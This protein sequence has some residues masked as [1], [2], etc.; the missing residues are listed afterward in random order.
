MLLLSEEGKTERVLEKDVEVGKRY[1]YRME[2]KTDEEGNLLISDYISAYG[3]SM[4]ICTDT[5]E[6]PVQTPF[7]SSLDWLHGSMGDILHTRYAIKEGYHIIQIRTK[8]GFEF[9]L[10]DSATDNPTIIV[11]RVEHI[12]L[13][14]TLNTNHLCVEVV[15]KSIASEITYVGV[16]NEAIM[17]G[18]ER[19]NYDF[20]AQTC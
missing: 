9:M 3:G 2:N 10:S 17:S 16:A 1:I 13:E 8:D 15:Y 11:S 12:D 7:E 4:V 18:L 14:P 5:G 19:M 6:L 20:I